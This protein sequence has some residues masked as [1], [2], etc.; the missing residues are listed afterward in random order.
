MVQEI[1][2]SP[3]SVYLGCIES[4][5]AG[6]MGR[7][8]CPGYHVRWCDSVVVCGL[9]TALLLVSLCS[10]VQTFSPI[11]AFIISLFCYEA[12]PHVHPPWLNKLFYLGFLNSN[13]L[14]LG[15]H[16]MSE[17]DHY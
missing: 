13:V 6:L 17:T 10:V 11:V 4:G 7:F 16:T 15:F 2:I 3:V 14:T 8:R 12:C 1:R 9:H 5:F